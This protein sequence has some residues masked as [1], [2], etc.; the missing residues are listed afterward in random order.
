MA[1]DHRETGCPKENFVVTRLP[2]NNK[3]FESHVNDFGIGPHQTADDSMS[4]LVREE[5]NQ[6]NTPWKASRTGPTANSYIEF[7]REMKANAKRPTFDLP[8]RTPTWILN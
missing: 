4:L 5:S 7:L 1:E 6:T 3:L 2:D 8:P